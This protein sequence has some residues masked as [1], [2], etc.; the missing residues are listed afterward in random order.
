MKIRHCPAT[1]SVEV[2]PA[3]HW[4][5]CSGKAVGT[6][7]AQV[8]SPARRLPVN[9]DGLDGKTVR[10]L[11]GPLARAISKKCAISLPV[12][13][14]TRIRVKICLLNSRT[15]RGHV[16][17]QASNRDCGVG[18]FAWCVVLLLALGTCSWAAP[19]GARR[20]GPL[21]RRARPRASHRFSCAQ[22]D[23]HRVLPGRSR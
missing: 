2:R 3:S 5:E 18:K 4:S 7:E 13:Y 10:R 8:R 9:R 1:V 16:H 12:G 21:R 14:A 15:L 6:G 22:S 20:H 11:D 17:T 19:S 23:R